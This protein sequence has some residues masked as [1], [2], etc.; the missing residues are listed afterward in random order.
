M[1]LA[2]TSLGMPKTVGS[3]QKQG[4][5]HGMDVPSDPPEGTNAAN[6][7]FGLLVCKTVKE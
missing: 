6:L 3:H 7:D 4:E 5:R 1:E 2:S